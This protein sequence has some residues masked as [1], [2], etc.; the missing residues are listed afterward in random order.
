MVSGLRMMGVSQVRMVTGCFV[1]SIL[2]MFRSLAM[3]LGCHLMVLCGLSMMV[4]SL[5]RVLHSDPRSRLAASAGYVP[6]RLVKMHCNGP[7]NLRNGAVNLRRFG[8]NKPLLSGTTQAGHSST[9][10]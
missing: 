5:F 2:V 7:V 8:K 3:M 10:S 4:G 1:I 9:T 6:T